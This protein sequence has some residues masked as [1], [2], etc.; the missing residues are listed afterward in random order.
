M[1]I[2]L[3]DWLAL[4]WFLL[5]ML[6]YG[7]YAARR[8][9]SRPCLSNTLSRY[10]AEWMRRMLRRENRVA[11]STI[12]GNLERNGSFFASSSL[13]I[14]AGIFT[15]L[16]YTAQAMEVFREIPMAAVTTRLLWELK[17]VV[18]LLVFVYAFFKFTWSMRQYNFASVLLGG[19]P[20][21]G[22]EGVTAGIREAFSS[23]AARV[24]DRAGDAFNLGLRGFYYALAVLTWFLH[25]VLFLM[26]STLVVLILYRREFRSKVLKTLLAGRPFDTGPG[27]D[28]SM[29]KG[30]E[31]P[32]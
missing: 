4:A 31:S 12:L 20:M 10:R 28:K 3:L 30:T 32:S 13:L 22:E 29:E 5:C 8:A 24:C 16:G 2:P 19:A 11:D 6:G 17:L 14:I 15:A 7:E 1:P 26:A 21:P 18:L 9:N 23:N 25:P 27:S